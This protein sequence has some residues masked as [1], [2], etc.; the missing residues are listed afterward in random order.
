[1][2]LR[3]FAQTNS[4]AVTSS[5]RSSHASAQAS[6]TTPVKNGG[7]P[8]TPRT[9]LVYSISP[10]T[11]PSLSASTPF[12][13]DAA[14]SRKPPPYSSPL[15]GKRVRQMQNGSPNGGKGAPKRAVR[16]KNMFEKIQ[17]IP[18]QIAFEIALFPH[19][20]PLPTPR[21]SAYLIGGFFHFLHLC[22]RISQ[23]RAVP[24]ADLG[25]EDMYRERESESWF[26]WTVPL[27]F[28]L[29]SAATLNTMYLFSR[30]RLY[31]LNL[32]KDPVSSPHAAFVSR[33]SPNHVPPPS[34][35]IYISVFKHA[36]RAF[37]VSV[38]FLLNLSPPKDRQVSSNG[39]GVEKVQQLEVWTPGELEMALFAIYSPVH[40]LLW[41]ALTGGNWML[42]GL[43]MGVVGMQTQALTRSYEALLKDRNILA[44]EVMHEYDEKFV[45]PRINPIRKDASVMTHQA[46]MVNIWEDTHNHTPRRQSRNFGI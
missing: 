27:T 25:W 35:P 20:V 3:R 17:A 39:A 22:I 11:S 2:S 21:N 33:E 41:M 29:I 16:K 6:P 7:P 31:Q 18:S 12:D 9:Q 44:K 10:L 13:W 34:T 45:Y 30:T 14:R 19:N 36:W 38:R 5:P 15:A 8:L 42:I 1:M 26:D 4:A 46:E 40:S 24:E 37:V 43:I 23:I 28:L 32:A